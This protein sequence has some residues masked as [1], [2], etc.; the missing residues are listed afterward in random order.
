MEAKL[1]SFPSYDIVKLRW[2]L[3]QSYERENKLQEAVEVLLDDSNRFYFCWECLEIT[4]VHTLLCYRCG[5]RGCGDCNTKTKGIVECGACLRQICESC[6]S[7]V[8]ED[9]LA[10]EPGEWTCSECSL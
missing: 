1:K 10:A 2:L 8:L 9:G 5:R 6:D 4:D 7:L 3:A